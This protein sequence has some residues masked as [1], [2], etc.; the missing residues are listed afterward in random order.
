MLFL[1]NFYP[2]PCHTLSHIP[3]PLPTVRHTSWTPSPIFRRASKKKP[4]KAP[5]TKFDSIVRGGFCRG[6]LSGGRLSGRFCPGWFLFVS[7][8][9]RIHL[10]QQKVKHH[11]EFHVS[12]V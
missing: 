10:L 1:A 8:S 11:F 2:L 7:P 4:R 3:G 12:Y 6:V 9:V 5:C